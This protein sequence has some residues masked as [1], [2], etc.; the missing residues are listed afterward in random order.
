M[1]RDTSKRRAIPRPSWARLVI[2]FRPH[3]GS[4]LEHFLSTI[5][6][7]RAARRRRR[8]EHN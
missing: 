5:L 2:E 4:W 6:E 7:R 1:S 3:P 8:E